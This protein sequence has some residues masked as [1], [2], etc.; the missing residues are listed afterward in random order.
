MYN[1]SI[2]E[3]LSNLKYVGKLKHYNACGMSDKKFDEND[4]VK[5]FLNISKDGIIQN[6]SFKAVGC[7]GVLVSASFICEML[8]DKDLKFAKKLDVIAVNRYIL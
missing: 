8:E 4:K 1:D 2:I 3:R 7:T 5:L 6:A